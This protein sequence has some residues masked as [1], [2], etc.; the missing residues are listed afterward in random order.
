M[1][2]F[3]TWLIAM[4]MVMFWGFRVVVTLMAQMGK[5]LGGM[6]PL[7]IQME[8]IL[9]F[10]VLVC[11]VLIVKRKMIGGLIYLLAYG[12]YFGVNI[13]NYT[14]N[15]IEQQTQNLGASI[16]IS[17][18]VSLLGI[19]LPIAVLLDL[20]VD[21]GRKAN[22]KDKKTDWFYK[23]EQYDRKLDERADKNNY[24]TL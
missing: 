10:V 1:A 20:L 9:A 18:F 13:F 23:N 19:I 2:N 22:P 8:I 7:N 11:L 4:F 6:E 14:M 12:M 21:K 5:D 16:H 3:S 17:A 15:I 24:R